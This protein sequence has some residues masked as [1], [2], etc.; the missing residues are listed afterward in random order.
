MIAKVSSDMMNILVSFSL[1]WFLQKA[2]HAAISSGDE[3]A[4]NLLRY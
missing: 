4:R 3:S 1:G 2:C